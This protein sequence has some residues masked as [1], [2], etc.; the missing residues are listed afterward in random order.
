MPKKKRPPP[1]TE[2]GR[3]PFI[4]RFDND[5]YSRLKNLAEEADVSVNQL[6]EGVSRWVLKNAKAGEPVV[7]DSG[8][9]VGNRVQPGCIW[10]GNS[11]SNQSG[12]CRSPEVWMQLDFT[13]RRVVV[14]D[15]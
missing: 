15:D 10:A 14:E 9:V 5:V 3:T 8:H 11:G 1:K 12:D 2:S 4:L 13:N 6:M 7:D